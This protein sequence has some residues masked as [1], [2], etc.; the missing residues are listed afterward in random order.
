MENYNYADEIVKNFD[1]QNSKK[2]EEKDILQSI[3]NAEKD[4]NIIRTEDKIKGFME[5][6]KTD[7]NISDSD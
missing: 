6:L 2:V 3:L 1:N 5:G 7:N 4:I